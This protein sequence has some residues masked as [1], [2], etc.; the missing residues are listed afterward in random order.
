MLEWQLV[1]ALVAR[2]VVGGILI[3]AGW[4]KLRRGNKLF[5][6]A[7]LAY[8]LLPHSFSKVIARVLPPLELAT[9]MALLVGLGTAPSACLGFVLIG[10]LTAAVVISLARGRRHLC[11]CLGFTGDDVRAIQWSL[12]ARNL[13]LMGL[14]LAV[15]AS[16]DVWSVDALLGTALVD[17]LQSLGRAG[18]AL[19]LIAV[20]AVALTALVARAA[21]KQPSVQVSP[22]IAS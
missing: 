5:R 13:I 17:P 18:I 7:V 10:V 11:G 16:A 9:G 4:A 15:P 6:N 22:G 1:A 2:L 19:W 12:A 21:S 8:D 20:A 14:L 3:A